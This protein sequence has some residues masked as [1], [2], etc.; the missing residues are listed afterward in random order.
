MA[1]NRALIKNQVV[2]N[3]LQG[4]CVFI[5]H[6]KED[7][8]VCVENDKKIVKSIKRGIETSSHLL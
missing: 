1:R 6:K 4:K 5:S 7:E 2:F 8:A 3:C